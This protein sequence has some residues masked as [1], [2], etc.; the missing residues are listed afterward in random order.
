MRQQDQIKTLLHAALREHSSGNL[1][2]AESLYREVIRADPDEPQAKH[3][4][5]FL[6]QQTNRLP[7]ALQQITDA[8]AIHAHHAEWHFNLGIIL[9][10]Q[11][12]VCEAIDAF[13]NAIAIDP[14]QYFF[15]TNL[16]ACFE[17][18][19]EFVRAEQCYKKAS[20][21][22]PSCPDAFY[23]LAALC[24][25]ME[26]FPEARHFNYCGIIAEPPGK[27]SRIARGQAYY[28]LGRVD[29]AINLFENWLLKE[30]DNPVAQHLLTA[31]QG[32]PAP[33]KC[34]SQYI[35][36]TFN[37]FA[38]S[39]ENTLNRLN[40][41]GPQLVYDYL[42]ALNLQH[43]ALRT[44]DLGCGTGLLGNILQLYASTL[45]GVDLSQGMLDQ[46]AEKL[47]YQHLHQSDLT[48]F[49]ASS[50]EQ[51]DLITCMDTFIYIGRLD[52]LLAL[53]Y[54]TLKVGGMLIFSTEKILGAH[55][56]D[57]QLNISGR[58]SHHHDY[59]STLLRHNGFSIL[60][61][62]DVTIRKESGYPIEGQFICASR[63]Q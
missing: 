49:L 8:I 16:G 58:Y 63:S 1:V 18:N 17:L 62:R 23:L 26:R 51:Y 25:K 40:Y 37:A 3:Y 36:Q 39:F 6:L 38:N 46:A 48:D 4:L 35:E 44:L 10:M 12:L 11:G 28:E 31:Y 32:T 34:S 29:E 27:T 42:A 47:A 52:K 59:L 20:T 41:A 2:A 33:E 61:M 14:E 55:K 24:L 60:S 5:G 22:N 9:S 21:I 57:Y 50:L 56:L 30:P 19:Q 13:S 54:K 45:T 15:W 53:I 43:S 7:E